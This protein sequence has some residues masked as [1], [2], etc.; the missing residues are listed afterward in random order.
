MA[1][2]V[3]WLLLS[4]RGKEDRRDKEMRG[5]YLSGDEEADPVVDAAIYTV[6]E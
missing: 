4:H 6:T 2:I 3:C 5:I 1:G